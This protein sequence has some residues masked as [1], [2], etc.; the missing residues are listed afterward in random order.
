MLPIT[1][2]LAIA[3]VGAG[4]G[5][6]TAVTKKKL[7]S[8]EDAAKKELAKAKKDGEKVV[9]EAREK[10][11]DIV[12]TARKED[13]QRRRDHVAVTRRRTTTRTLALHGD[14]RGQRTM[15]ATMRRLRY[16]LLYRREPMRPL[17]DGG[18][19]FSMGEGDFADI[20]H[21]DVYHRR[22]FLRPFK[23]LADWLRRD[24]PEPDHDDY[25]W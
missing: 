16:C 15:S 21:N 6:S 22:D 19:E 14:S 8:A 11:A 24:E 3:G 20:E 23:A 18:F 12:E 4:F 13:Q 7:G 17:T 25:D 10:A 9:S 5:A 1:I 2:V